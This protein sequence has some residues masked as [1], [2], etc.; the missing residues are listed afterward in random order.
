MIQKMGKNDIY[1]Q[2][3]VC[4]NYINIKPYMGGKNENKSRKKQSMGK[5]K[6][7]GSRIS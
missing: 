3:Q 2:N 4:K 6:A 5:N 7:S 1:K